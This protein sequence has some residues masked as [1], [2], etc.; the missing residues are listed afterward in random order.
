MNCGSVLSKMTSLMDQLNRQ[1][2]TINEDAK[3]EIESRD[4]LTKDDYN[5]VK[6]VLDNNG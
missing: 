1:A 5:E 6:L 3:D 2:S 4:A